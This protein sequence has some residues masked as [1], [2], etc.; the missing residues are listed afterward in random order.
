MF[1]KSLDFVGISGDV[2][3]GSEEEFMICKHCEAIHADRNEHDLVV[4]V[5]VE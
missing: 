2:C 5:C 4:A 3:K 1:A